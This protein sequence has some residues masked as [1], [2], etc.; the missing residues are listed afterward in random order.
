MTIVLDVLSGGVPSAGS[1]RAGTNASTWPHDL[2]FPPIGRRQ[3]MLERGIEVMRAVWAPGTSVHEGRLVDL[4]ETTSHPRPV[5]PIPIVVGGSGDRTL[6]IAARAGDA[7]NV[8]TA[9][10]GDA[11]PVLRASCAE[12]GRTRRRRAPRAAGLDRAGVTPWTPR[13]QVPRGGRNLGRRLTAATIRQPTGVGWAWLSRGRPPTIQGTPMNTATTRGR[14]LVLVLTSLLVLTTS[15]LLGIGPMARAVDGPVDEV[16][17]ATGQNFPDALAGGTL[18]AAKGAPLLLVNTNSIP[19]ATKDA[20]TALDPNRIFIIGGPA[21]VSNQ[22]RDALVPYT[23]SGLVTRVA[24]ADRAATAAEVA[25][26]LPDVSP[27][28]VYHLNVSN[29]ATVRTSL[30]SDP[31]QGSTVFRPIGQPTGHYCVNV[32][33][34]QFDVFGTVAVLQSTSSSGLDG[35]DTI[36]VTSTFSGPCQQAGA[37]IDVRTGT[38]AGALVNAYFTLLIPGR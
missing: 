27:G 34:G 13:H 35:A 36:R 14:M 26:A 9:V 7:S 2:P 4:P 12:A 11:L 33:N 28:K 17:V 3:D 18:A 32:P 37:E 15:A 19:S 5:H 23:S 25:A 22:V 1:A 16:Y 20:L 30:T 10:L 29:G 38:D 6:G 24:G 21:A 31:L 8:R